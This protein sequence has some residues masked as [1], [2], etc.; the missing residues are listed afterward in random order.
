MGF[1]SEPSATAEQSVGDVTPPEA[2]SLTGVADGSDVDLSWTESTAT[3]IAGYDI[4]R[5]GVLIKHI[6]DIGILTYRDP[7]LPNGSYSYHV[8]VLDQVGNQ[9][10]PSNESII[11]MDNAGTFNLMVNSDAAGSVLQLKWDTA[12]D[13]LPNEYRIF[14]GEVDGGIYTEIGRVDGSAQNY[15]D[16]NL[17]N[18]IVRYYVVIAVDDVGEQTAVSN[19]ASGIPLDTLAPITPL[20]HTPVKTGELYFTTEARATISGTTEAAAIV[21][22]IVDGQKVQQTSSLT[23]PK[24]FS[25]Q[26]HDFSNSRLSPDGQKL[27]YEYPYTSSL[28]LFD[29][30]TSLEQTIYASNSHSL[31]N[32]QWFS[33][34]ERI[35][36]VDNSDVDYSSFVRIYSVKEGSII[37]VT[38][39]ANSDIW[40]AKPSPDGTQMVML[41]SFDDIGK[42]GLW[43][44]DLLTGEK[45]L[46]REGPTY[47]F[48]LEIYQ[49]DSDSIIT[50]GEKADAGGSISWSPD[51]N[52]I[53]YQRYDS[54]LQNIV[55]SSYSIADDSIEMLVNDPTIRPISPQ[56]S[57][58]GQQIAYIESRSSQLRIHDIDT[59]V[60]S[61]LLEG[62]Y[63][64][65]LDQW[66]N[67][68]Y[69]QVRRGYEI[70]RITLPG[71]FEFKD[72]NLKLGDNE[73]AAVATDAAG[74]T[75]P[76]SD[77][78]VIQRGLGDLADLSVRPED[79]VLLPS[80]PNVNETV[81]IG[82]TVRNLGLSSSETASFSIL[83]IDPK[84][85]SVQLVAPSLIKGLAPGASQTLTASW[86]VGSEQGEHTLVVFVDQ[87]NTVHELN[88]ANNTLIM[89]QPV[90]GDSGLIS[91]I[92][93]DAAEYTSNQTALITLEISNGGNAFNGRFEVS[94]EDGEGVTVEKI[95]SETVKDLIFA[96]S[97]S[98]TLE[99]NTA[100][101]FAG[102]Y[103]AV[104]K[105]W[106]AENN[107][108]SSEATDFSINT[109]LQVEANVVTDRSRYSGNSNVRVSGTVNYTAGNVV[110]D[111]ASA[112]LRITD[113]SGQVVKEAIKPLADIIPGGNSS[114]SMDWNTGT[115]SAGLYYVKL[116]VMQNSDA[117]TQAQSAFEIESIT[118][119]IS[120]ALTLT[121]QSLAAG[122]IQ[123][124]GFTINNAGNAAV[125][126]IPII[127]SLFDTNTL[128]VLQNQ[129]MLVDIDAN[130]F[131]TGSVNFATADLSLG[132][133]KLL[134]QVEES[135]ANGQITVLNLDTANFIL[136]DRI[137]PT[138]SMMQPL[139]GGFIHTMDEVRYKAQDMLSAVTQSAFQIDDGAWM[140]AVIRDASK[141]IYGGDLPNLSEAEHTLRARATDSA[142]N[143]GLSDS[144]SFTVDN[145]APSISIDGVNEGVVYNSSV[146]PVITV[147]D[148]NLSESYIS[149]NEK[150]YISGTPITEEGR[151][152][153]FV[154]VTD[155]AGNITQATLSFI[156]DK[157]SPLIEITGVIDGQLFNTSVLPEISITDENLATSSITLNAED[158]IPGTTIVDEGEYQLQVNA[159]DIAGNTSSQKLEFRIDLTPPTLVVSEP[160]DGSIVNTPTIDIIGQTEPASVVQLATDTYQTMVMADGSGIFVFNAVELLEGENLFTLSV[161]DLAGNVGEQL[162]LSLLRVPAQK[163][164][165]NGNLTVKPRVLAWI[166]DSGHCDGQGEH[167]HC[168][169]ERKHGQSEHDHCKGE[170]KSAPSEYGHEYS[171]DHNCSDG[172]N[173]P[174][175]ADLGPL[176]QMLV[177]MFGENGI[178]FKLAQNMADFR[179]ALSSQLYN[180]VLVA[181]DRPDNKGLCGDNEHRKGLLRLFG[182]RKDR[183]VDNCRAIKY[184]LK[185]S[186][187]GG[188]GLVMIST[189]PDN[190]YELLDIMGGGYQG[191]SNHGE[192]HHHS[193]S[194]V[195]L[196]DSPLGA[197]TVL[198][199]Q[200]QGIALKNKGGMTVATHLPSNKPALI[201]N[202]YYA[203]KTALVGFNP[204]DLADADQAR[205]LLYKLFAFAAPQ[206]EELLPGSVIDLQWTVSE[207][208][209]PLDITLKQFSYQGIGL[210]HA[211]D[212]DITDTQTMLWQRH[213]EDEQD[214]FSAVIRLPFDK[215]EFP[216][217]ADLMKN[218]SVLSSLQQSE[219]LIT[220]DQNRHDLAAALLVEMQSI[221][222]SKRK[223]TYRLNKAIS[224]VHTAID[225]TL[226]T[227]Q[228]I[229]SALIS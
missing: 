41:G 89:S 8:V 211:Y 190:S 189:S 219:L 217:N 90:S 104:S 218:D 203:G 11:T 138:V 124:V 163:I 182:H 166:P 123:Q 59:G 105:V 46:L 121:E 29:F 176:A 48:S 194:Q 93:M 63:V 75:S 174:A 201:I 9:S 177:E 132:I 186:V 173:Q 101:T 112:S 106:D 35:V 61:I 162:A 96:D 161:T 196:T 19:V 23:E 146:V 84:G 133:Y 118:M 154:D 25:K 12:T 227:S 171:G 51:S 36:F 37:D 43:L 76:I 212:G 185:L 2:V 156:I 158:F 107:L 100:S 142:G 223:D 98:R 103:R 52:S 53:V 126:Q 55:I 159:T 15:N 82:I 139:N 229:D 83:A 135:D 26:L 181:D 197:E 67:S 17:Q 79:I 160:Q 192:D 78:I 208:D 57:P 56:W 50:T 122:A 117:I 120:G 175:G 102:A 222:L 188:K 228:A 4:Y 131:T 216:I 168:Q 130:N 144:I 1:E 108:L 150:P 97:I 172:H 141:G 33:D 129:T 22:L 224:L 95:A 153:L 3:D 68:G 38:D 7:G 128:T 85:Q 69:L 13:I 193:Y 42:S 119:Q 71:Y 114:I 74:N 157:T 45:T 66:T 143:T 16:T 73:V 199:I 209:P 115:Q 187:A 165:L 198:D 191:I 170:Q 195:L 110:L 40:Q 215:G 169:N 180:I 31:L 134:L 200:G 184:Q 149:L 20:I 152:T 32:P 64:D 147:T 178:D 49:L 207:V 21:D 88:E 18:E 92:V 151:Y 204:S 87:E 113:A 140:T 77:S 221:E 214:V 47:Q 127:V 202:N 62:D 111:G 206:A 145:T 65:T 34:G 155:L 226:D 164:K 210:L 220:T 136:E 94:I 14:R 99:W 137:P 148:A 72:V 225:T 183:D 213:I 80:I 167:A 116:Q 109:S 30:A 179:Q 39:P 125:S 10:D 58:D 54:V 5:D 91:T 28:V 6:T 60:E 27:V 81:S 24:V 205:K 44:F 70:L 86:P